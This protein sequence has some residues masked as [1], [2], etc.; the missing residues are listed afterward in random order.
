[1]E[2]SR[3]HVTNV[4]KHVP[5]PHKKP[6]TENALVPTHFFCGVDSRSI[7]SIY[8]SYRDLKKVF[9]KAASYEVNHNITY[10]IENMTKRPRYNIVK[11]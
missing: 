2:Y 9:I 5:T 7:F 6:T 8:F 1:M 3:I 10:F 4:Y 11:G